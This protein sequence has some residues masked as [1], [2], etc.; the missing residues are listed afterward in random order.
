MK[1]TKIVSSDGTEIG[2]RI[3]G[4]GPGVIVLNGGMRASEHYLKLANLL[5]RDFT[6]Y[7]PDRRGRQLSGVP[8]PHYGMQT[9][10]DDLKAL[11]E[12]TGAERVFGHSAGALIALRGAQTFPQIKKLAVY[13]PPLSVQHNIPT[14]DWLPQFDEEI[15]TRKF[16]AAMETSLGGLGLLPSEAMQLPRW[17]RV[18]IMRMLIIGDWLRYRPGYTKPGAL[19]A[20]QRLDLPL[21]NFMND[22]T[23]E[24]KRLKT[25]TLLLGGGKTQT[26]F[27]K[28]AL[29]SLAEVIP[30]NQYQVFPNLEHTAPTTNKGAIEISPVLRTFFL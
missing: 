7:L 27:L 28:Q 14:H 12:A 10:L 2:Y 16:A 29:Q 15:R 1:Q 6:V 21:V 25:P 30:H 26:P 19:V 18:M 24:F 17:V 5:A 20:T 3:L 4:S 9:E 8:G 22:T 13:E 23:G 11:L